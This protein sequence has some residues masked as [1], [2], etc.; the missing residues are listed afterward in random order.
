MRLPS[1]KL[2]SGKLP[3]R[4]PLKP[5]LAVAG[6][7]LAILLV[8]MLV[9]GGDDDGP[10]SAVE[11]I[12]EAPPP[13]ENPDGGRGGG[14]GGPRVAAAIGPGALRFTASVARR[15]KPQFVRAENKGKGRIVLGRV[16]LEGKDRR[17]FV[18]TDG[19]SRAA[20]AAGEACTVVLSFV[21]KIRRDTGGMDTREAT[22]VF[23]DDGVRGRRSVSISGSVLP[24]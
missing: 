24:R 23:S 16:R 14:G 11:R 21:P 20:L 12:P 19:C 4:P 2:P 7:L 18:A 15:S 5:V 22:V 6:A 17:D 13:V 10:S 8:V 1:P 9:S 3:S